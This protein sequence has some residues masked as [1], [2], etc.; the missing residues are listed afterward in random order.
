MRSVSLLCERAPLFTSSSPVEYHDL[1][2]GTEREIFQR[3]QLGMS[4]TA[5]GVHTSRVSKGR[6]TI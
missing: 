5:A 1:P 2:P 3:V 6:L 4:L